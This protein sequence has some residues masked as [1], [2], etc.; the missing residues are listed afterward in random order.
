MAKR[1]RSPGRVTSQP[2]CSFPR[3]WESTFPKRFPMKCCVCPLHWEG[4]VCGDIDCTSAGAL[5]VPFCCSC[6]YR[7]IKAAKLDEGKSLQKTASKSDIEL[8][9]VGGRVF[10]FLSNFGN[11]RRRFGS[12]QQSLILSPLRRF[13]PA[14]SWALGKEPLSVFLTAFI[15]FPPS[16][17]FF[18]ACTTF[19]H[20]DSCYEAG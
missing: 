4:P 9:R 5:R 15:G 7:R 14:S 19:V 20:H 3:I 17:V 12:N 8:S 6:M 13:M 2:P 16:S 11:F 18:P 10:K 1:H